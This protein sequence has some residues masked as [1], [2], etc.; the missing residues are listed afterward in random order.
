MKVLSVKNEEKGNIELPSQFHEDIRP[1]IIKRTVHA[2]QSHKRQPYGATPTAGKR[3][4]AKLSRRRRAYKTS[5]GIGISRVPRKVLSRHGTR[6][7]W[8]GAF[9]PGTVGGRRSHPPKAEKSFE[10]KV[11]EKERRK[12][13]RSA[14][15]ATVVKEIVSARGHVVPENYPIIVE[16][17]FEELKKTKE[18]VAVL[19]VLGLEN[20]ILRADERKVRSGK[21]KARGRK[22]RIKAGPLIVVSNKCN[23]SNAMKNITGVDVVEVNN[24]NAELLAPGCV[25]GRLTVWTENAIKRLEKESLF[26]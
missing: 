10:H 9:A 8:V 24:L 16:A 26:M 11:N 6:M 4:S 12:A 22:Y 3:S 14:I 23:A 13:I 17:G 21:G 20:E 7:F 25:P 2:L 19:N 1:D 18:A 5:Y 15:S